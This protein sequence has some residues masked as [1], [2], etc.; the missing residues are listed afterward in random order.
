[1]IGSSA[2]YPGLRA[3][4][5]HEADIF[6]GRGDHIDELLDRLTHTRLLA[7]VGA[8]GSGK[9]SLV[10]AGLLPALDAG[11]MAGGV[12]RWK[13]AQM[14]PSNR[15]F[16]RLA[17]ALVTTL[18][19]PQD[20]MEEDGAATAH[21]A[22]SLR[23]GPLAMSELL[24]RR[25]LPFDTALLILV[26]QFEELIRFRQNID[27]DEADAFVALLLATAAAELPVYVVLTMRSDYLGPCALFQGL[28]EALNQNQYL[29]PRLTREQLHDAIVG[30]ARMFG[31]D[32]EPALVNELLNE[33][34]R[35]QD[36]LPVLQH[37]LMRMWTLAG[38][39]DGTTPQSAGRVLTWSHYR[40]IG[41]LDQA[42]SR[43]AEEAYGTL[44]PRQ[45]VLTE[46][47]FRALCESAP[48]GTDARRPAT[49]PFIGEIAGASQE[50]ILAVAN[51]FRAPEYSFLLP[52]LAEQMKPDDLLDV[53]HESLIRLWA[54][55]RTW[56]QEE[57][58]SATYY[59][60]LEATSQA[61]Q[62]GK[63]ALWRAPDLEVAL[64]WEQTTRPNQVWARRYGGDL[65]LA[66]R[67]LRTSQIAR[68][69]RRIGYLLGALAI[70]AGVVV[71]TVA[72]QRQQ[73][74]QEATSELLR[75]SQAVMTALAAVKQSS[76]AVALALLSE[77]VT[78]GAAASPA[79][80]MVTAMH[81]VLRRSRLR[82]TTYASGGNFTDV[83]W[84]ARGTRLVTSGAADGLSVWNA[85]TGARLHALLDGGATTITCLALAPNGR[86]VASGGDDGR[87]LLWDIDT[88]ALVRVLPGHADKVE[89]VALSPDGRLVA[90]ASADGSVRVSR[91][92]DG[93]PVHRLFGH[94]GAAK[95]VSFSYDGRY[96]ASSGTDTRVVVWDVRSGQQRFVLRSPDEISCIKFDDQGR[97][98]AVATRS[99]KVQMWDA[100]TRTLR[101]TLSGHDNVVV[102]LRFAPGSQRLATASFDG[103]ARVWDVR[104]GNQMA[105]I[106]DED[107]LPPSA[108]SSSGLKGSWFGSVSF[109]ADGTTLVTAGYDGTA[110]LWALP[111]KVEASAIPAHDQG[112]RG[113]SFS[114]E[115]R[116]LATA[117]YDGSAAVWRS[118]S[119]EL[120]F[121]ARSEIG[122]VKSV[123]FDPT[124]ENVIATAERRGVGLWD[125]AKQ[126]RL[127]LLPVDRGP[128][129]DVTF[130]PDGKRL[131]AVAGNQGYVFDVQRRKLIRAL[132][133]EHSA[134]VFAVAVGQQG[135]V[136]ATAG[137]DHKIVL[138]SASGD[139][140]LKTLEGHA[141]GILDLAFM[142]DG[143][144][145]LSGSKD[146]EVWNWDVVDKKALGVR[147]GHDDV[148]F[149]VAASPEGTLVATA[150][151]KGVTLWDPRLGRLDPSFPF[152][153]SGAESVA[154]SPDGRFLVTGGV[155]GIVRF[156]PLHANDLFAAAVDRGIR[157]LT[158]EECAGY[159]GRKC[160]P[161]DRA[162]AEDR[163]RAL[164]AGDVSAA[165][166][167]TTGGGGAVG[168]PEVTTDVDSRRFVAASLLS[169][170]RAMT[171]KRFTDA[172]PAHQAS[173]EELLE[174]LRAVT[175]DRVPLEAVLKNVGLADPSLSFT[176]A[177]LGR[178]LTA[179]LLLE[180]ADKMTEDTDDPGLLAGLLT[181]A[182]EVDPSMKFKP[183]DE[184]ARLVVTNRLEAAS[185]AVHAHDA[186]RAHG[187]LRSLKESPAL[188]MAILRDGRSATVL[189][190]EAQI[191]ATTAALGKDLAA[192]AEVLEQAALERL[193][194][195]DFRGALRLAQAAL[196]ID[197]DFDGAILVAGI[198]FAKIKRYAEAATTLDRIPPSSPQFG[199]AQSSAGPIY[200]EDLGAID[201]GF[202]RMST[203]LGEPNADGERWANYAEA[204]LA[205]GRWYSA[206]RAA[207]LALG[208]TPSVTQ[209]VQLA[210][211]FVLCAVAALNGDWASSRDELWRAV[212][213]AA[214]VTKKDEETWSY[215][216]ITRSLKAAK[217]GSSER[218]FI[219]QLLV[220]VASRG[221]KGN[222]D[223]L[224]TLLARAA[225]SP[226]ASATQ[227]SAGRR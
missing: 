44:S 128:T 30:P 92:D 70:V 72:W 206:D 220:F 120:V 202:A 172:I 157:T 100:A 28:P 151:H 142:P 216:G 114:H 27:H 195:R 223:E 136:V 159:L 103:T 226:R 150:T 119:H 106:R 18:D 52:P 149:G 184:A 23:R 74:S 33:I 133:G 176:P 68:R 101:R 29:T 71:V 95:S 84:V 94:A 14:R 41:G 161:T 64:Q 34:G 58:E 67:F 194:K 205:S 174:S 124:N 153:E 76:P 31:G 60:R 213:V 59:R 169:H 141:I 10:K 39:P 137:K 182:L 16:H 7:V 12:S 121:R 118:E 46:T 186:V 57:A 49:V 83:L 69:V 20:S 25:S 80:E 113:M 221:K 8:S 222:A 225:A 152:A 163:R 197:P 143:R 193:E 219:D 77:G 192:D 204:A 116:F 51:V 135:T 40:A 36:Q 170:A 129:N 50:E 181:L 35:D 125:V 138:W 85:V 218:R 155:D 164:L 79:P 160:R 144:T 99:G 198:A 158:S 215:A 63:A 32:V 178:S 171:Y 17:E 81:D 11:F 167:T 166:K 214:T 86:L 191:D 217:M 2:P 91:V 26:D 104:T 56:A 147:F 89:E 78:Q 62:R 45:Q 4:H 22:V 110:R 177:D 24:R 1:V 66:V 54:R 37:A 21:M 134:E 131:Y 122:P 162:R 53:S 199:M 73:A 93:V 185:Q 209:D 139:K 115:G 109:G 90:S 75:S 130:S 5:R 61:W 117:S 13:V 146:K 156:Y 15:P 207:R 211:R 168:R 224:A 196:R 43:H 105:V 97:Y 203:A 111:D 82:H 145:L 200:F 108:K 183:D 96:L 126:T 179:A 65:S 55:L 210:M 148:V 6:F 132:E 42:L 123:A 9:S 107:K 180:I 189:R 38:A 88:P 112:I 188:T 47:M 165:P 3:Y 48:G 201:A 140:V 19:G 208:F 175:I 154:F 98:L 190:V 102:S 212:A 127:D 227:S 173:R 87:V 187:V